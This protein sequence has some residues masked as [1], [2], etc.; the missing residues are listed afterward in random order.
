VVG[1]ARYSRR[2]MR[3]D[4]IVPAEMRDQPVTGGE[5]DPH[6]PF[7]R[8]DVARPRGLDIE[9]VHRDYLL[10]SPL[11]REREVINARLVLAMTMPASHSPGAKHGPG[12]PPSVGLNTTLTF[13]PILIASRSQSTIFVII[14]GPS[15][16]VT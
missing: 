10:R 16:S 1:L 8:A 13:W 2:I 9:R 14:V 11:S 12:G 4:Q 3:E 6:R 15:A 7:L 5:I